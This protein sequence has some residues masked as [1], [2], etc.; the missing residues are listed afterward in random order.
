MQQ[1]NKKQF[2]R[3]IELIILGL[4][5]HLRDKGP[6]F[7]ISLRILGVG[8]RTPPL[9][10][11]ISDPRFC[12]LE[13]S[14]FSHQKSRVSGPTFG[15]CLMSYSNCSALY[16]IREFPKRHIHSCFRGSKFP[17]YRFHTN[18]ISIFTF[19][20]NSLVFSQLN[21]FPSSNFKKNIFQINNSPCNKA[22]I[23]FNKEAKQ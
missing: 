19:P 13:G 1:I 18:K 20:Q 6:V 5:S 17:Y 4:E 23:W 2:F 3:L 22:K 21:T 7:Q 14:R 11:Q 15:I 8:S 9:R 16:Y 10:S 12:L